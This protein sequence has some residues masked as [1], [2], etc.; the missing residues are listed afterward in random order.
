MYVCI[1]THVYYVHMY[2]HIYVVCM[3]VCTYTCMYVYMFLTY[4]VSLHYRYYILCHCIICEVYI[5][6]Y[7]VSA[8]TWES[9]VCTVFCY[10]VHVYIYSFKPVNMN[11]HEGVA[12]T[13]F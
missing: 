10:W 4:A 3:Y 2:M 5:H 9:V 1:Y 11:W 13:E 8:A 6:T 12:I 7:T